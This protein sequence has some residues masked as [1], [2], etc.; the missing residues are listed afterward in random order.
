MLAYKCFLR[1]DDPD[2]ILNFEDEAKIKMTCFDT[3]TV[4][5][6]YCSELLKPNE[7]SAAIHAAENSGMPFTYETYSETFDDAITRRKT[8]EK[9]REKNSGGN[10]DDN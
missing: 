7:L 6:T 4:P 2:A 5:P 9:L 8:S 1:S 10:K 3:V